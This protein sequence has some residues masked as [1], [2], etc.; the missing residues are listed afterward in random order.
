MQHGGAHLEVIG[1]VI[2]STC[3]ACSPS[4]RWSAGPPT[5]SAGRPSWCAGAVV[6]LVSLVLCG[7]SP[8]GASWQIVAGLFLLGLGWSCATV[9]ASTVIAEPRADRRAHRRAGHLRHGD[10]ADRGRGGG[11][12]AGGHRRRAGLRRARRRSRPPAGGS[13]SWSPEPSPA[14]T[15]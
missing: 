8:E 10:G 4:R 7:M 2:A 1:F 12:L 15:R 9:A 14:V 5:A 11:A 13:R 6:L 3:S